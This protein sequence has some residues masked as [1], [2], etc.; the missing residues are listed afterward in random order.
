MNFVNWFIFRSCVFFLFFR[1]GFFIRCLFFFEMSLRCFV[2]LGEKGFVF[3][4]VRRI[5]E[6]V[7]FKF[8][9]LGGKFRRERKGVGDCLVILKGG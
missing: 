1:V 5:G 6:E 3:S 2:E 8:R 4:E 7:V 9:F